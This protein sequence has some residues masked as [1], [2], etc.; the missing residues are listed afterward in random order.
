MSSLVVYKNPQITDLHL[1]NFR[2]IQQAKVNF[3]NNFN[4]I[5]GNNAEGKTN[6]LEL[7]IIAR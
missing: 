5:I 3:H 6:F 2:N 1:I 7:I 4:L